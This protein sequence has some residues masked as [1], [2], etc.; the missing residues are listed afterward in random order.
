M[1]SKIRNKQDAE[2]AIQHYLKD[3]K[4]IIKNISYI[5]INAHAQTIQGKFNDVGEY[6]FN[7]MI[8]YKEDNRSKEG[9]YLNK[10]IKAYAIIERNEKGLYVSDIINLSIV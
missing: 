4:F 8:E 10:D 9:A 7:G 6:P 2:I 1:E 3:Y 5:I